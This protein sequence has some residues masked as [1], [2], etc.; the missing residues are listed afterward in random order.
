LEHDQ[1]RKA[2]W[3]H[4]EIHDQFKKNGIKTSL[5]YPTHFNGAPSQMLEMAQDNILREISATLSYRKRLKNKVH[6]FLVLPFIYD[7]S[8]VETEHFSP[9]FR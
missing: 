6:I 7:S 5:P 3:R 2:V 8:L 4:Q 9:K 1:A